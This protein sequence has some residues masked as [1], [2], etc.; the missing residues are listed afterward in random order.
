MICLDWLPELAYRNKLI[1][2]FSVMNGNA[3]QVC[4]PSEAEAYVE[5]IECVELLDIGGQK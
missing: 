2:L 4:L 5:A 3:T 1:T